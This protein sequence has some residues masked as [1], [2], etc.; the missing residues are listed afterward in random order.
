ML[1]IHKEGPAVE[2]ISGL[3]DSERAIM[4][5]YLR[6]SS[7]IWYA[8]LDGEIACIWGLIPPTLLSQTAYIWLFDTDL[9]AQH[10]FMLV[11]Q[12]QIM[13]AQML[14]RYPIIT[15]HCR[16]GRDR[17]IAWLKWLGAEFGLPQ[18]AAIPFTIRKK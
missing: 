4:C 1:S 11:R 5:F 6:S 17:S 9:C 14:E 7:D 2:A 18:G 15:G 16:I 13:M 8:D 3:D 10:T 12:S